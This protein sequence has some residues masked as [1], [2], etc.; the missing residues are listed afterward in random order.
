LKA[1]HTR[2]IRLNTLL[3]LALNGASE[4]QLREKCMYWGVTKPTENSYINS[5]VTR[6]KVMQK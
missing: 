6:L 1:D 3:K 5:V 2:S 4:L